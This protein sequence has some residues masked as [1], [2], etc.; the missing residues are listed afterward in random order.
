MGGL[1]YDTSEYPLNYSFYDNGKR[2]V[3]QSPTI[4]IPP[5]GVDTTTLF[6]DEQSDTLG[7]E[8]NFTGSGTSEQDFATITQDGILRSM[9]IAAALEGAASA[10]TRI[11]WRI[12]RGTAN[13]V[14]NFAR[15]FNAPADFV[16]ETIPI[17]NF[18]VRKG[19]RFYA[20]VTRTLTSGTLFVHGHLLVTPL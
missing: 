7:A 8:L 11:R 15:Y 14:I 6:I 2:T 3:T 1:L 5:Q 12:E 10:T 18:I 20:R 16:G 9:N 13:D 4:D 19:D 17:T